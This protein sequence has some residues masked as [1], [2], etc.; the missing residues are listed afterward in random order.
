MDT[1]LPSD[2]SG[3][4]ATPATTTSAHNVERER[5]NALNVTPALAAASHPAARR[6]HLVNLRHRQANAWL[7]KNRKRTVAKIT[8][9]S[10]I[11]TPE[12]AAA[13]YQLP[14]VA[15]RPKTTS[16]DNE[17]L[18]QIA[19]R[20]KIEQKQAR[21]NTW[22][23]RIE[24]AIRSAL[25]SEQLIFWTLLTVIPEKEDQLFNDTKAWR[26]WIRQM[27]NSATNMR[28]VTVT[29]KGSTG[30]LHLHGIFM[31][32]QWPAASTVD[33]QPWVGSI[34]RE[35]PIAPV[36]WPFG[37]AHF[38][39]FRISP[40]DPWAKLG[41]LWPNELAPDNTIRAIRTPELS[42]SARY[43]AKYITKES[44]LPWRIKATHKLGMLRIIR[45]LKHPVIRHITLQ[46]TRE[47]N[48]I[49][50]TCA[51]SLKRHAL[52]AEFEASKNPDHAATD[53]ANH[54]KHGISIYHTAK[55]AILNQKLKTPLDN[56]YQPYSHSQHNTNLQVDQQLR[57][58]LNIEKSRIQKT[59]KLHIEGI[60]EGLLEDLKAIT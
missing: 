35:A 45:T 60:D 33:P 15:F 52:R 37:F 26:Q 39:T 55:R 51:K 23:K 4:P 10:R 53:A 32:D 58:Y 1:K 54:A 12:L 2:S 57:H 38:R 6:T 13:A 5:W 31:A 30:K 3:K 16:S 34:K 42:A 48:Q 44:D 18:K 40:D 41:H 7:N 59:L 14:L 50:K 21:A 11:A 56:E 17:T 43:L 27:R 20:L 9:S 49:F 22:R 29:E 24:L 47:A 28:Y 25:R 8:D 46:H 19:N 36:A